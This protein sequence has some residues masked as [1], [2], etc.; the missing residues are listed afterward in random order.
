MTL[1]ELGVGQS[2]DAPSLLLCDGAAAYNTLAVGESALSGSL[3]NGTSSTPEPS[4][5]VANRVFDPTGP[6]FL[7]APVHCIG[8]HSA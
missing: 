8:Y 1:A 5:V 6:S 3:G 7:C 4:L 2:S